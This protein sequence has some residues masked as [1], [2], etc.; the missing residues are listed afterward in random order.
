MGESQNLFEINIALDES[1]TT[2][3][4][5]YNNILEILGNI[6]GLFSLF[7]FLI[8]FIMDYV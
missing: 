3:E 4:R 5:S 6:G 8:S 7:V 1:I 2:T